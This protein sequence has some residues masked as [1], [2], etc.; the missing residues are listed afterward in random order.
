M[1]AYKLDK[2]NFI[3]LLRMRDNLND[4]LKNSIIEFGKISGLER[5]MSHFVRYTQ[6]TK[7]E[8]YMQLKDEK[9]GEKMSED[10]YENYKRGL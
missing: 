10:E 8:D 7:S 9:R 1:A 5:E 3:R 6:V 2:S 4:S